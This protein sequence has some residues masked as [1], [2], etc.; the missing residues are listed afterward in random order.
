M[1][2]SSNDSCVSLANCPECNHEAR[3]Y[4]SSKGRAVI[5]CAY[6]DR[7]MTADCENLFNLVNTWNTYKG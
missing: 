7:L 2:K 1:T 6:C 3:L 4:V 5:H